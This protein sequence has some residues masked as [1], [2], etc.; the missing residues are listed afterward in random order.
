MSHEER[1]Q[2]LKKLVASV[3]I[4]FILITFLSNVSSDALYIAFD[5]AKFKVVCC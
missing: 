5:S 4:F 3:H 1:R 2:F